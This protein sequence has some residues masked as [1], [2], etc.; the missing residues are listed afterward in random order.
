LNYKVI[1]RFLFLRLT[2]SVKFSPYDL[3]ILADD[4]QT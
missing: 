3:D 1:S 4:G 2:F